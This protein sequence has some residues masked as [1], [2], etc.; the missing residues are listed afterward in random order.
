MFA[1]TAAGWT[2]WSLELDRT[3]SSGPPHRAMHRP[4]HSG[5]LNSRCHWPIARTFGGTWKP[6]GLPW[7]QS[8]AFA[9]L[10]QSHLEGRDDKRDCRESSCG[11]I[12]FKRELY[13]ENDDDVFLVRTVMSCQIFLMAFR[14]LVKSTYPQEPHAF[15]FESSS[16][17]W[18][19]VSRR[20]RH[21]V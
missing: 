5:R 16:L 17:L 1:L 7:L 2:S 13:P 12:C 6:S 8:N 10:I 15:S 20:R 19:F 18:W 4:I 21:L 3:C 9:E 11:Y 14:R